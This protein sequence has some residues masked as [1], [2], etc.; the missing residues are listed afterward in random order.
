MDPGLTVLTPDNGL[1]GSCGVGTIVATA[2]SGTVTLT[3][4]TLA[5]NASCTFSVNVTVASVYPGYFSKS[6][7]V[8][9]NEGGP[10]NSAMASLHSVNYTGSTRT[11]YHTTNTA[12]SQRVDTFSTEIIGRMQ[13]GP[14]LYDQTFNVAYADP[15]VQA[16]VA[17]AKGVLTGGGAASPG[18]RS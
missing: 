4:A 12:V 14:T 8:S 18:R 17:T 10:G 11:I 13:G 5:A 3:G 7:P 6:G 15:A 1:T 2:G 9:S 16:A